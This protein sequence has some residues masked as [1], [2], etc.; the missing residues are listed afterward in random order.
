[1][2]SRVLTG[3]LS[4]AVGTMVTF[5][6]VLPAY[7]SFGMPGDLTIVGGKYT[8]DTTPTFTW[9][10]PSGATWYDVA[11]DESGWIGLSNVHSYTSWKLNDGWHGFY[12][13]AHNNDGQTSVSASVVF[14]VDT[15]GPS[16]PGVQ[17]TAAKTGTT[18]TFSV[19]PTGEAAIT[20][21][22]LYVDAKDVGGMTKGSSDF[23]KNYTFATAGSHNVFARCVDGD[24]NATSGAVTAINVT[25]G[26]VVCYDY[27]G[28]PTVNRGTLVKTAC[29]SYAPK[30]DSCHS[31][32]YYGQDGYRHG[33]TSEA[34]YRSWFGTS[35]ANVVT[36]SQSEM[37]AMPIGENVTMRPGSW[38]VKFM[39]SSTVY[40]VEKGGVLR[41]IANE[42]AAKAIYGS[43]WNQSIAE[44]SGSVKGDYTI[45]KKIASSSD[46]S[47][48]RAYYS[49]SSIDEN[50]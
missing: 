26:S 15:K 19:K 43:R 24:G 38:L 22:A 11:I 14:E 9:S 29:G 10:S 49:V 33:F 23:W 17:Y 36:I 47:G 31:I 1:M 13:R 30:S 44:L 40:A 50:F 42:A 18:T 41:P 21:C 34:V 6:T 32:Y 39:G 5:G 2:K 46:Y 37:N 12:V 20:Y 28:T 8:N 45:G 35:Y 48:S 27:C 25:K 3:L 16:V 7:A 4:L